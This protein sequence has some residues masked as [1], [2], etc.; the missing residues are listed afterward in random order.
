[1]LRLL[2][3]RTKPP[4]RLELATYAL[5]KRGSD[6]AS[7]IP[8]SDTGNSNY[9]GA[10]TGAAEPQILLLELA[11]IVAAWPTL[12]GALRRAMLALVDSCP[13]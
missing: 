6:S 12:P 2:G 7:A 8:S 3:F 1:M 4:A 10:A 5:R 13:E 11:K 9:P